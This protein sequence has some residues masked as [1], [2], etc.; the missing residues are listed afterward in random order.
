MRATV[1]IEKDIVLGDPGGAES[2]EAKPPIPW[3]EVYM[4]GVKQE[5]PLICAGSLLNGAIERDEFLQS[6]G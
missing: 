5:L 1:G 3:V 2:L 6:P 4:Y